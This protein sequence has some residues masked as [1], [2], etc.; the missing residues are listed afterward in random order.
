MTLGVAV[1]GEDVQFVQSVWGVGVWSHMYVLY[2]PAE[3]STIYQH[4]AALRSSA[5]Y[6][7]YGN[8][9]STLMINRKIW[10]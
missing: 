8:V 6:R 10:L 1:K 2:L 7:D 9:C 5:R 4:A 3:P